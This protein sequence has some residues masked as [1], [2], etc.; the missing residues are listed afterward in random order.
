M[1]GNGCIWGQADAFKD[2]C[3]ICTGEVCDHQ[4]IT[5]ILITNLK[6]GYLAILNKHSVGEHGSLVSVQGVASAKS[7]EHWFLREWTKSQ[8]AILM[9]LLLE[10]HVSRFSPLQKK[11]LFQIISGTYPFSWAL[12]QRKAGPRMFSSDKAWGP[13]GVWLGC[14]MWGQRVPL[15]QVRG[16][17]SF[18]RPGRWVLAMGHQNLG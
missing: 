15:P 4:W 9:G 16:S 1:S 5:H 6:W 12:L 13:I 17:D 18:A 10:L 3:S 11:Q 14:A 2:V 7:W 8:F